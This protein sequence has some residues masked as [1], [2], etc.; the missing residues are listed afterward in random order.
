VLLD[1][2]VSCVAALVADRIAPGIASWQVAATRSPEPAQALALARLQHEPLLDLRLRLGEGTGALLAVP[3]LRAAAAALR[4]M[5][6]FA[7]AGVSGRT[8]Q[9]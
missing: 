9:P 2:V 6:T 1:G 4:E 5:A 7:E 8:E 3:L